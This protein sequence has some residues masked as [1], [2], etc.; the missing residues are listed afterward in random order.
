MFGAA[1]PLCRVRRRAEERMA[2]QRGGESPGSWARSGNVASAL[3]TMRCSKKRPLRLQPFLAGF[4]V[5]C[6]L[7]DADFNVL[8]KEGKGISVYKELMMKNSQQ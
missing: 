6:R 3:L 2:E 5:P 1:A 8:E 7:I 4:S